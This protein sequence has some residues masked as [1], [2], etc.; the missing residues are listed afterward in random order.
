[1]NL[2]KPLRNLNSMVW[3]A[4]LALT[5]LLPFVPNFLLFFLVI[6]RCPGILWLNIGQQQVKVVSQLLP[7]SVPDK[8]PLQTIA[9]SC[10]S[11]FDPAFPHNH[12]QRSSRFFM[13]V[14]KRNVAHRHFWVQTLTTPSCVAPAY[15]TIPL[16][17]GSLYK[18]KN[19]P[20]VCCENYNNA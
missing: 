14:G 11:T 4:L 17:C 19:G 3:R 8:S 12:H 20:Q 18:S 1:M 9:H 10:S 5:G 16:S 6:M 13:W 7:S 15:H 2:N